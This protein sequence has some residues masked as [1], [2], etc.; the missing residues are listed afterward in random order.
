MRRIFLLSI[1]VSLLMCAGDLS[2]QTA[3]VDNGFYLVK[4]AKDTVRIGQEF[5]IFYASES[6]LRDFKAPQFDKAKFKVGAE[7]LPY[8]AKDRPWVEGKRVELDLKGYSFFITPVDTGLCVIPPARAKVNGK[9]ADSPADTIYVLPLYE[10]LRDCSVKVVPAKPVAG[11]PF[12]LVITS[13]FRFDVN[14]E[15]SLDQFNALMVRPRVGMTMDQ[16]GSSYTYTFRLIAEQPGDYSIP[17]F[18]VFVSKKKYTVKAYDFT[19]RE[20]SAE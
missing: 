17:P 2:A 3:V 4:Y 16:S 8:A 1:F 12:E 14:P 7:S 18:D 13:R 15:V 5:R 6:G 20:G 9:S 10:E 11:K 19:V